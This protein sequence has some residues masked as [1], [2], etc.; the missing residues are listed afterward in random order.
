M[1]KKKGRENFS[2]QMARIFKDNFKI[3]ISMEKELIF[4]L[5]EEHIKDNG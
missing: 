3:I 5:M 4:G 1:E 2:G